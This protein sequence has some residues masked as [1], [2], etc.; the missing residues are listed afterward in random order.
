MR[1]LTAWLRATVQYNPTF[2]ISALLLMGGVYRLLAPVAGATDVAHVATTAGVIVG[3]ELVLVALALL[4]LWPRRVVYETT[5]ALVI[6][7]VLRFAPA[8]TIL[9]LDPRENLGA[10]L[11]L[12][13]AATALMIAR[14]EVVSR[15]GQLDV[16]R[17]E[18]RHSAVVTALAVLGLPCFARVLL[19]AG[20]AARLGGFAGTLALVLLLAPGFAL[21]GRGP[22][23]SPRPL[24][25]RLPVV[26]ARLLEAVSVVAL[27]L[28]ALWLNDVRLGPAAYA[29]LAFLGLLVAVSTASALARDG[30][31][32]RLA[33]LLPTPGAFA[34]VLVGAVDQVCGTALAPAW[35]LAGTLPLAIGLASL[36][37]RQY[38]G[39]HSRL[40]QRAALVAAA[41]A[42]LRVLP[43][44]A[45]GVYVLALAGSAVVVGLARRRER[46]LVA[47]VLAL[48]A[49]VAWLGAAGGHSGTAREA[50]ALGLFT[51]LPLVGTA[52]VAAG[53]LRFEAK[54]L[55]ASLGT[56][57]ILL[58][59][60]G[61]VVLGVTAPAAMNVPVLLAATEGLVALGLVW[62]R[63]RTRRQGVAFAADAALLV[64]GP[65]RLVAFQL[66]ATLGDGVLLVALAFVALPIGVLIGIKRERLLS[67]IDAR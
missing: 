2:P 61:R 29:P 11:A 8:V 48:A 53:A 20:S 43:S 41:A 40:G 55:A 42:P 44:S 64:A 34:L 32:G 56:R 65:A 59:A 45:V 18:R 15:L 19:T 57:I 4:V 50:Q 49:P 10:M 60:V 58:A 63:G 46:M 23:S 25:S 51:L 26:V 17:W 39:A 47:G 52:L 54:G 67:S 37:A 22:L 5:S 30:A 27:Y 3:Y 33:P 24:G 66:V 12:G 14:S 6:E 31:P 7:G 36:F 62:T 35:F 9:L 16:R 38:P 28:V 1:A 13:G 21:L